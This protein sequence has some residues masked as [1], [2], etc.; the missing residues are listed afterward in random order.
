MSPSAR[1]DPAT[2]RRVLR[3]IARTRDL[4]V[5]YTDPLGEG[6]GAFDPDPRVPDGVVDCMTWVQLV[7]AM[8]VGPDD[9]PDALEGALNAVRYYGGQ[10]DF[11]TRKHFVD[12]WLA[13]EP[14]PLAPV[15][16]TWLAERQ[17]HTVELQPEVFRAH[18]G[19]PCPLLREQ[20]TR[21]SVDH[22]PTD[23][24][25]WQI[26]R[27]PSAVYLLTGIASDRYLERWGTSGP[28]GQVHLMFVEGSAQPAEDWPVHH[29][30]IQDGRVVTERLGE[31]LSESGAL[32]RGF[33]PYTVEPRS[34]AAPALAVL[35]PCEGIWVSPGGK[36]QPSPVLALP[37]TA[38]TVEK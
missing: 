16:L 38:E 35:P 18:L 37:H 31:F 36:G 20:T 2:D 21:F 9:L 34:E 10:V 8:A 23:D 14:A 32:Y 27:L 24:L 15:P 25:L 17:T 1:A 6:P 22:I 33:V 29:A 28:M 11:R 19:Y 12:R 3:A 26:G 5:R 4:Q 7:L 13:W 30:S